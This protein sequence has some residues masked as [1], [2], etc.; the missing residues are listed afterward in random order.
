MSRGKANY[1]L[2]LETGFFLLRLRL[3]SPRSL[4]IQG[5][6]QTTIM[7]RRIN[8]TRVRAP[9]FSL[10]RRRGRSQQ[11]D[12]MTHATQSLRD[13]SG[14]TTAPPMIRSERRPCKLN[15]QTS[16]R[17]AT[18]NV[19]TAAHTGY[20]EAIV[21][22]L[23]RLDVGI[24][25]ITEARLKDNGVMHIDGYTLLYSGGTTHAK[26]VA[27][28][29][30]GRIAQ[31]LMSWQPV[32]DRLL[33][34]R[35]AHKHGCISVVVAYAPTEAS[36]EAD[37]DLFYNQ[38]GDALNAVPP[39]DIIVCLGDFNA[40]TGEDRSGFEEVVGNFGSGNRN[41]NSVRFLS[42]C[43]AYRLSVIGSFYQRKDIYRHTWISNDGHTRKEIDHILTN[44]PP[45]FKSIRV[46]RGAEAPA[47]TDHRIVIA[48]AKLNPFVKTN[49]MQTKKLDVGRLSDDQL[50]K[51]QYNIAVSNAFSVL[52]SLPMDS[53]SAWASVRDTI[54]AT[55]TSTIPTQ[56]SR[57]R[58]WLSAS[59]L[60]VIDSKRLARLGGD[61]EEC[62]R[63]RRVYKAKAK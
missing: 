25:G 11:C 17:L 13:G 48:C 39:H 34:A 50:L 1:Q 58:P 24:A 8:S 43:A 2:D 16:V 7:K 14:S 46:Y 9:D 18:W 6:L 53:E 60:K 3:P 57:N 23:K 40:V 37:K 51:H 52:G 31:S 35:L 47:L 54:K 55:A 26:G 19:L 63:L 36:S 12:N 22:E 10:D 41:D 38:L 44:K 15:L 45:L 49:P 4:G 27:L 62:K 21:K 61:K 59:T 33:C 42:A 28:T 56:R 5:N 32:S 29:L 30:T 20:P